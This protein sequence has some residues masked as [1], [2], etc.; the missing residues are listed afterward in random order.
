MPD[1]AQSSFS[2]GHRGAAA[3]FV[4]NG[5]EI[6]DARLRSHREVM[7]RSDAGRTP[8]VGDAF[9]IQTGSVGSGRR[10]RDVVVMAVVR[11]GDDWAARCGLTPQ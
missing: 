3:P 7:I 5:Y 8:Q 1:S 10:L 2:S 6:C 11:F 4:C 9:T